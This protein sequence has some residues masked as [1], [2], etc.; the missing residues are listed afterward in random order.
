M[1]M[2]MRQL[3]DGE[4][5][6]N[7]EFTTRNLKHISASGSEY[8]SSGI[9]DDGRNDLKTVARED[10]ASLTRH[11]RIAKHGKPKGKSA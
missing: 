8:R 9:R 1:Q 11:S 10:A 7:S 5:E 6:V 3:L 4:L 2:A